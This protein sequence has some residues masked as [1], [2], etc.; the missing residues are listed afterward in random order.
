MHLKPPEISGLDE[1]SMA[2]AHHFFKSGAARCPKLWSGSNIA[3]PQSLSW[4]A[5][6]RHAWPRQVVVLRAASRCG[7]PVP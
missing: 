7:S 5:S 4:L 1:T 3:P 2:A 6:T